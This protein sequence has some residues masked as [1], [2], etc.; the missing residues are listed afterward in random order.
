MEKTSREV[1]VGKIDLDTIAVATL[2]G[3]TRDDHVVVVTKASSEELQDPNILCIEVGGSGQTL[4]GNFDH[5]DPNG[6]TVSASKQFFELIR[7]QVKE[8]FSFL[9]SDDFKKLNGV[10]GRFF[11]STIVLE[12]LGYVGDMIEYVNMLDV[13]GP[14]AIK[15]YVNQITGGATP[16]PSLSDVISGM[17][18]TERQPLEQLHRGVE[19]LNSLIGG[20]LVHSKWVRQDP[21][22]TIEGF[23]EYAAA[24]SENNRLVREAVTSAS[25]TITNKERKLGYLE[26][27]FFGAPGSL[28]GVGAEVV[29]VFAPNFGEPPVRKFTIAGNDVRVDS[30]LAELNAIEP[31]WGGPATGTIIGSPRS[32]SSLT[33]DS[34]VEIVKRTC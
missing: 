27:D 9:K 12:D 13:D 8:G 23:S 15:E 7:S 14:S 34:V 16:Y 21:F 24:K 17:L 1:R 20:E 33:L 22:G 5:H 25:W 3:V 19:I 11:P 26:T 29:V 32:G 30:A 10:L 4:R 28:Y 18:L 6:P 2:C 31:G